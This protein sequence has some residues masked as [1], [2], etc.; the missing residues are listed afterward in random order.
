MSRSSWDQDSKK[1]SNSTLLKSILIKILRKLPR[2][3]QW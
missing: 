2:V 3:A 1:I